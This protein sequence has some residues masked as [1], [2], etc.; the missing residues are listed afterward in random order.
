MFKYLHDGGVLLIRNQAHQLSVELLIAATGQAEEDHLFRVDRTVFN[1]IVSSIA[2][3]ILHELYPFH[4]APTLYTHTHP[5]DAYRDLRSFHF[6]C[7]DHG[8][9]KVCLCHFGK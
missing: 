9:I 1:F 3:L 8:L 2:E 4:P 5:S 6:I 7:S